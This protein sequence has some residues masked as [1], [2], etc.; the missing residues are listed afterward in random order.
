MRKRDFKGDYE[1]NLAEERREISQKNVG[2][3]PRQLENLQQ[4][5]CDA[6]KFVHADVLEKIIKK[7][8]RN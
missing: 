5:W 8:W 7:G 3:E 1:W 2:K 4:R 6:I